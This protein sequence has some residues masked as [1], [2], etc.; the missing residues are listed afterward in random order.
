MR[1]VRLTTRLGS[2]WILG[3]CLLV[4]MAGTVAAQESAT[5]SAQATGEGQRKIAI[6]E[7]TV[8]AEKIEKSLQDTALSVQAFGAQDL[9]QMGASELT[10]LTAFTPGVNFVTG[11][12]GGEM[13]IASRG[14]IRTDPSPHLVPRVGLY[15]DG[16]YVSGSDMSLFDLIDLERVEVLKG[17]QGT[18]FGRNTTGG[19]VSLISV[20]PGPDFEGRIKARLGT[21]GRKDLIGALNVPLIDETLFSRV[22][23]A[24]KY[25]EHFWD[26]D[27][28][29]G[30]DFNDDDTKAARASLRWLA[31]DTV[32][33]DGSF[34][35]VEK[36][37]DGSLNHLNTV[38][39]RNNCGIVPGQPWVCFDQHGRANISNA[40]ALAG[41]N[42]DQYRTSKRDTDD[43]VSMN[44]PYFDNSNYFTWSY[45]VTWDAS[46]DV[47]VKLLGGWRKLNK[48]NSYDN[49]ATP[50]SIFHSGNRW[51]H[52][53]LN[54]ELQVLG[55]LGDGRIRYVLGANWFQEE[56]D[57]LTA[58]A[59]YESS[60]FAGAPS[61]TLR[62]K[63]V[64]Y[65]IGT[66]A[67]LEFDLT[68][69]LELTTAARYTTER[70]EATWDKCNGPG[71]WFAHMPCATAGSFT[72]AR[73]DARFDAWSPMV[74]LAYRWTDELMTY[75]KWAR[76]FNAGGFNNRP[77]TAS[78]AQ[79]APYEAED[80]YSWEIGVKSRWWDN[81]IQLNAAAYYNDYDDIQVSVFDV[82]AGGLANR[83]ENAGRSRIRGYEVD[84]Q[85]IPIE[86]LTVMI[87]HDWKKADYAEWKTPV[88]GVLVDIAG[89]NEFAQ[90]PRRTWMGSV[91]YEFAPTD[92]GI[93]EIGASFNRQAETNSLATK[94]SNIYIKSGKY[95]TYDARIAL[96][97]AFGRSGLS[98]AVVGKNV[99]DLEYN[100][101]QGIDFGQLGFATVMFGD[102][103]QVYLEIGYEF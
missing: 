6:E 9:E 63:G 48:H 49:D 83:I 57:T 80:L 22:A 30:D 74:R 47:T 62:M 103:R 70:K 2:A 12:A 66:F 50:L 73:N 51:S 91:R 3:I 5:R 17:P 94:I 56:A 38:F 44:H 54:S 24:R 78:P 23:F 41:L 95:T 42:L 93:L 102:P 99:T 20:K 36:R 61:N 43:D 8:T 27:F 31:T 68:D 29:G 15:V 85:M 65:A 1:D 92:L 40:I 25:R 46:E 10:D 26:N 19:A 96:N 98:L 52:R 87:A 14:M 71:S 34:E 82:S 58:S 76:G 60:I 97:D 55:N 32:T 4:L 89:D 75:V 7:I 59:I 77:A 33:V 28:P 81:R 67:H 84:L 35:W 37:L 90:T 39:E 64:N 53:T 11:N 86:G 88:G 101:G 79:T 21:Y 16:V 72:G 45:G 100:T 69:Q 18:L 13:K